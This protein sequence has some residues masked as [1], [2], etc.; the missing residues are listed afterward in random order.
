MVRGIEEARKNGTLPAVIP[1]F[2]MEPVR[3]K[4]IHGGKYTV[5][6]LKE[7]YFWQTGDNIQHR[8][9]NRAIPADLTQE[10]QTITVPY[11]RYV[12]SRESKS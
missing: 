10:I 9:G 7:G 11:A 3:L 5:G 4:S 6:R 1:E 8:I 12:K 2:L